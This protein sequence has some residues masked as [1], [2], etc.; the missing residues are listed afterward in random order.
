MNI[1]LVE[2]FA[3]LRPYR[4]EWDQLVQQSPTKTVFQTFEWLE[5]LWD[6]FGDSFHLRVLLGFEGDTLVAAAPLILRGKRMFGRQMTCLE[7]AASMR[8]DYAD[9]LYRGQ[10]SLRELIRALRA[11]LAWD[12]LNLDRIPSLSPTVD[13]LAEEFPGWRGTRFLDEVGLT[14]I[15]GP[16][17]DGGDIL[18]KKN[19][20]RLMNRFYKAGAVAVR[21]LTQADLIMPE[22]DAFFE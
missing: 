9:F 20:H 3:A 8:A 2:Q 11:E 21:H 7:F 16:G 19:I 13:V 10:R 14:Y 1:R 5:S 15:V 17:Q 6:V 12:V 18:A 22:L 4:E